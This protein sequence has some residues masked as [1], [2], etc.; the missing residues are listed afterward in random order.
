MT[1]NNELEDFDSIE[2]SGSESSEIK[3]SNVYSI[4]KGG[5][6]DDS[7]LKTY[8]CSIQVNQLKDD[9]DFYETLTKDKSWPISQ[10]IQR[11][12]DK[13]RV[14]NIAKSYIEGKG[15]I[16]TYFPPIIVALLPKN[17]EGQIAKSLDFTID[18]SEAIKEIIYQKSSF[19]SNEPIKKYIV[20]ANNESLIDG[21]YVLE[22]SKVFDTTLLSWDKS[23]HYA[24]VIDGQ[25]RLEALFK[26]SNSNPE[27]DNYLQD[28]I[29]I[30]FSPL[31]QTQSNLTPVEVVRR[32]FI[33][34]NTN[35]RSVGFVRQILM[36]DKDLASLCIQS[37]VDSVTKSGENKDSELYISSQLVDWYG[38]KL[39]HVLPHLTG[40]L[41]LYQIIDDYLIQERL[42]SFNDLRSPKKVSRWVSRVNDVFMVDQII[43]DSSDESILDVTSLHDS[44]MSFEEKREASNEF[45]SDI[46]DEYKESEIF[47]FDYRVLDIAQSQFEDI[48][49]RALV[50]FFNELLPLNEAIKII[51]DKGG[52]GG[53]KTLSTALISSRAKIAKSEALKTSIISLKKDIEEKLF[54]DFFLAYTVLGQKSIFNV[55]FVRIQKQLN[56]DMNE[57]KCIE[58]VEELLKD[59]NDLFKYFK[60]SEVSLFADKNLVLIEN[61][62]DPIVDLGTISSLFWEGVNYENN[63]IIYNSQGIR[64]LS[65]ILEEFIR[66]NK[67]RLSGEKIEFDIG[68]TPWV[69]PRIKRILKKR[70]DYLEEQ[71]EEYTDEILS[72]KNKYI[73]D[74]FT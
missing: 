48:Y 26:S 21:L 2:R 1:S 9:V 71:N 35:A 50:K 38:D 54:P 6:G 40:I 25:H 42:T 14:S 60:T 63:S 28:V 34:I 47:S 65:Y 62:P 52:F 37:L 36:D 46:D 32:V 53:D 45:S 61:L 43:K 56:P 11:E 66:L 12:V 17:T 13:I 7:K 16:I 58:I 30:D 55:L 20:G 69:R 27:V 5:F 49:L 64:S 18:N 41:S 70:F 59:L 4:K 22:V 33:D 72:V 23:K 39:K 74:Y 51:R 8:M 15:R 57:E 3:L 29:F 73:I 31:I 19:S 44:L 68:K 24:I 10:I 67:A